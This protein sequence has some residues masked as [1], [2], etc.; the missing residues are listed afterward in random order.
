MPPAGTNW[1]RSQFHHHATH[2]DQQQKRKP[3]QREKSGNPRA[4][5]AGAIDRW[6]IAQSQKLRILATGFSQAANEQ[7]LWYGYT[8]RYNA[9]GT[10]SE[11]FPFPQATPEKLRHRASVSSPPRNPAPSRTPAGASWRSRP[12]R[13]RGDDV[14]AP[15]LIDNANR[16]GGP[17]HHS[18]SGLIGLA[19]TRCTCAISIQAGGKRRCWKRKRRRPSG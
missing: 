12:D 3:A 16:L 17:H 6:P 18:M 2:K 13:T 4:A 15:I 1:L 7:A 19:R 9:S 8:E 14:S 10:E 5:V 11:L